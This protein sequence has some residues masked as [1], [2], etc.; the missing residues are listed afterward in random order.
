MNAPESPPSLLTS[1]IDFWYAVLIAVVLA[2][3][4]AFVYSTLQ[5]DEYS[6]TASFL[7]STEAPV[8]NT[9]TDTSSDSADA[10]RVAATMVELASGRDVAKRAANAVGLSTGTVASDVAIKSEGISN[11]VSVTATSSNPRVAARLADAYV[12]EFI[13][14]QRR[15]SDAQIR[16]TEQVLQT[17]LDTLSPEDEAAG[18][19]AVLRRRIGELAATSSE[20]DVQPVARAQIPDEPSSPNT[21]LNVAV[22]AFVGLLLGIATAAVLDRRDLITS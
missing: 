9:A 2:A 1:V 17:R 15:R 6:A 13:A 18:A 19:D 8:L 21:R 4:A 3:V 12:A 11:V 22:G 20:G 5:E 10:D 7:F 14:L 16:A